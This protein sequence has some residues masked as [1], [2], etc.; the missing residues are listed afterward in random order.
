MYD[1]SF[2]T[3]GFL[4]PNGWGLFFLCG[5]CLLSVL[6]GV[7]VE[8]YRRRTLGRNGRDA[9]QHIACHAREGIL[10]VQDLMVK[11][12]NPRVFDLLGGEEKIPDK[13]EAYIHGDDRERAL[14]ILEAPPLDGPDSIL[15]E[16][17]FHLRLLSQKVH[18]LWVNFR[19]V[20]IELD[21]RPA[22][23][24]YIKEVAD[25]A[26]TKGEGEILWPFRDR[27][28]PA[29]DSQALVPGEGNLL[30]C[31]G[32]R[33]ASLLVSRTFEG[34]GYN[35]LTTASVDETLEFLDRDP[36][37]FHLLIVDVDLP[38]M[39]PETMVGAIG[40]IAPA[41]PLILCT[42]RG[43]EPHGSHSMGGRVVEYLFK[44][45][46]LSDLSSMVAR[47]ASPPA[48]KTSGF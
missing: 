41:L 36:N 20:P 9:F 24:V 12:A 17:G 31:E 45:Y 21:G 22:V 13:I 33:D 10:V 44:P 29:P 7:L 46:S 27:P 18:S 38:G 28:S 35:V 14:A 37:F 3:M 5:A 1:V 47:Y 43:A 16:N 34:L 8:Q 32:D 26:K 39:D 40:R 15:T 30:F 42:A 11:Y 23:L 4:Y 48:A 2:F 25:V 19:L 6:I